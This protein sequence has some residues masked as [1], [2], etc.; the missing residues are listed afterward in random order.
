MTPLFRWFS[1]I[2][3]AV[4]GLTLTAVP[5]AAQ[6]RR[7][8][9]FEIED[10]DYWADLCDELER[11]E[12]Y[13]EAL[14]ACETAIEIRP[15]RKRRTIL[16]WVSRGNALRYLGNHEEA[17]ASYNHVLEIDP[18][19]S[20]VWMYQCEVLLG[21][22]RQELALAA[23][24]RALEADGNW[25]DRSPAQAWRV[26]AVVFRD[27]A[28]RIA[29]ETRDLRDRLLVSVAGRER[30]DSSS[31]IYDAA[32]D[33]TNAILWDLEE[34]SVSY[35]RS[36][37]LEPSYALAWAQHC[38]VLTE[39]GKFQQFKGILADN[40]PDPILFDRLYED[41]LASCDVA[42]E[43][44]RNWGDF[45][46]ALAW[47][48]RAKVLEAWATRQQT[49]QNTAR[50]LEAAVNSY[51]RALAI[52]AEMPEAWVAQGILL[53]TLDRPEKALTSYEQSLA[54]AP[55][56]SRTLVYR[57]EVLNRL[58]NY[59]TA[60]ESCDRALNGDLD[61]EIENV[62]Q[63]W[64]QRSAALIGLGDYEAALESA[65]RS[66]ALYDYPLSTR[67]YVP[68]KDDPSMNAEVDFPTLDPQFIDPPSDPLD[69]CGNQDL[70]LSAVV[71]QD[72]NRNLDRYR[73]AL[74]NKAV[75]LWHLGRYRDARLFAQLALS[76]ESV[77]LVEITLENKNIDRI[78]CNYSQAWFNYGRILSE[79]G[80]LDE[81][82]QAYHLAKLTYSFYIPSEALTATDLS[83]RE[84]IVT[85]CNFSTD[86]A[87]TQNSTQTRHR[88]ACANIL[89]NQ[90]ATRLRD[91]C[92]I[93]GSGCFDV[94]ENLREAARLN[95][96]SFEIWYNYGLALMATQSHE[97]ALSAFDRAEQHIPKN[98][99]AAN[100]FIISGRART[101]YEWARFVVET[102]DRSP[103]KITQ[104]LALVE[105]ALA[106]R[107][108]YS[109]ARRLR[110]SLLR[111]LANLSDSS[112]RVNPPLKHLISLE[113][114]G[115]TTF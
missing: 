84:S 43:I 55:E 88:R 79:T 75:S 66:I 28:R 64:N 104:A 92:S 1:A 107:P 109:E 78:A 18:D 34:A 114:H 54:R 81:S 19:Y 63:A 76:P 59:E 22:E 83:A 53:Q 32:I 91:G 37:T 101:F 69:R 38:E 52:D 57:C 7:V 23:C 49:F 77:R 26:R 40:P 94:V 71:Q 20:L 39:I 3:I 5:L 85:N 4:F 70:I 112:D 68:P 115:K 41:A 30:P 21:M 12:K 95:P 58:G 96:E 87:I 80:R 27:R 67:V 106:L 102:P 8:D 72:F 51:E 56:A 42:I 110:D 103:A 16:V 6:D 73:R 89:L 31:P 15:G 9:D 90:S 105:Q 35:E 93:S 62:A 29:R 10:Y 86:S 48:H 113:N 111:D 65:E 45:N 2:A 50:Y 44:D 14:D 13:S 100:D 74:N 46:L 99:E 17:L 47:S 24:E 11:A 60:L 61:W 108:Q 25:G 33:D 98:D 82:L 97:N 36:L